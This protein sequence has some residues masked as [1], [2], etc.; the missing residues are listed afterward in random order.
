M[1]STE[2]MPEPDGEQVSFTLEH[3][4][5]LVHFLQPSFRGLAP[6]NPSLASDAAEIAG[7]GYRPCGRYDD[8]MNQTKVKML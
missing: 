7:D 2:S 5:K 1:Y 4:F 6:R 8:I 3:L